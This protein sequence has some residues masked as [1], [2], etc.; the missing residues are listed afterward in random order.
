V[1]RL[2]QYGPNRLQKH[3]AGAIHEVRRTIQQHPGLCAARRQ[4]IKLMLS[5]WID[6]EI[7]FSVVVLN[8]LLGFVQEGKAASLLPMFSP[9]V[10]PGS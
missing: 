6:A 2:R 10:S 7:I 8:A 1:A 9:Q 5:V 4:V 3:E